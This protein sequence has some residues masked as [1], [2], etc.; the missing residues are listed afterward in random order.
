MGRKIIQKVPINEIFFDEDLYP[1]THYNWQTAYDYS[2][3]MK[4]GS[5]F[6]DIVL[7]IF[8]R[9]KYLVDGKHRIEAYKLLKQG[10]IKAVIHIG[11]NKRRIYTEALKANISHGR[12][13]SPYEKRLAVQKLLELKYSNKDISKFVQV[14]LEKLENFVAKKAVVTLTGASTEEAAESAMEMAQVVLKSGA[15][16]L[17]GQELTPN[18]IIEVENVQRNW[19][20]H[21][22]IDLLNQVIDLLENN[23]LDRKNPKVIGLYNNLKKIIINEGL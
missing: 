9:K 7:A 2:Q 12:M 21:S 19:N 16:H 10:E 8:N 3:S 11:W 14:P 15:G 1:R 6:P 22:Q 20:M 5:K 13:L 4:T 18:R 23:L 17:S